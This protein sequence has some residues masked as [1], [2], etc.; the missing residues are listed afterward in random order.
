[1]FRAYYTYTSVIIITRYLDDPSLTPE[2][3]AALENSE[4]TRKLFNVLTDT[5]LTGQ[6][7]KTIESLPGP[8]QVYR[9]NMSKVVITMVQVVF[10]DQK[11]LDCWEEG[12]RRLMSQYCH[13]QKCRKHPGKLQRVHPGGN[14]QNI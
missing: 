2:Q 14:V 1:M 10:L 11:C 3:Q 12:D 4:D 9:R 8:V 5:E 13:M 6:L 7:R